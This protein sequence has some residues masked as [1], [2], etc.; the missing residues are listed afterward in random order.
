MYSIIILLNLNYE[1][2]ALRSSHRIEKIFVPSFCTE[3]FIKNK[4]HLCMLLRISRMHTCDDG[5]FI[6]IIPNWLAFASKLKKQAT[7]LACFRKLHEP[8]ASQFSGNADLWSEQRKLLQYQLR[9][10]CK[11]RTEPVFLC[12]VEVKGNLYE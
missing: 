11:N 12:N 3:K 5:S 1:L 9:Y 10:I 7:S 4:L 2:S 8:R 6:I